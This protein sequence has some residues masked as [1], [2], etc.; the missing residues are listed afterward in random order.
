MFT[1]S[2]PKESKVDRDSLPMLA[3][4]QG[5]LRHSGLRL[6]FT[7][8][9]SFRL[10]T[11]TVAAVA[12][13]LCTLNVALII[14]AVGLAA[15]NHIDLMSLSYLV[16]VLACALVGG[17]VASA[18]PANAVGWLFTGSALS[19]A[20]M[21]CTGEY[22]IY[23]L[24]TQ[25][26]AL[27]AAHALAWPQTWLWEPGIMLIVVF[28]PLFFPDGRL[29]SPRWRPLVRLEALVAGTMGVVAAVV[30]R[31]AHEAGGDNGPALA[32]PLGIGGLQP[33]ARLIG[34]AMP[35]LLALMMV[36]SA[37]G[38]I[39]RFR[40][41]T[42]ATR[43]QMKWL[44]YAIVA[45]LAL[46]LL[47]KLYPPAVP[48]TVVE[49]A[50]IPVAV[51]IAVLHYRL[52]DIDHLINRTLVYAALTAIVAGIYVLLVGFVT[53]S[54]Q[55]R[56]SSLV[57]P[58]ATG[59]VAV[60]FQPLRERL[61]RTVNRLLYGQRDE[62]YAVLSRLGLRLEE[63]LAPEAVLSAIV[64]TVASALK[65][66]YVG[67]ALQDAE[68]LVLATAQGTAVPDPIR[69]PLVYQ[70]EAVGELLLAPRSGSDDFT[71][72][73]RRLLDDL[74]RQAGVAV[75]AV[76]LTAA[77]KRSRERLVSARD[78]ERRRLRRDL[79]DGLG[80]MLASLTLKLDAAR[81]LLT[82]DPAATDRLLV[83]LKGQAKSAVTDIR[84]LV[85][86][87]RPPALDDLGLRSALREQAM[88][89]DQEGLRVTVEVPE[90]LPP[91]PAAVEV[92][93]YR[94]AQEAI[95][96]VARHASARSCVVRLSLSQVVDALCLEIRDDGQG[97]SSDRRAGV[98]LTSMR[99]RAE[100]LGGSCDI[101][102]PS[103]GGTRVRAFLP[104]SVA[105]GEAPNR[106]DEAEEV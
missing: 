83:D 64:E 55:M 101:D 77:L 45:T 37:S 103:T 43:A 2:S 14:G 50:A 100:E 29:P 79:H 1:R 96:N 9:R 25:P 68:G 6:L 38:L 32:N 70:R 67:I 74:A 44:T 36:A 26:G 20:L 92:A 35:A 73:D 82:R 53:R 5:H 99:E 52:Y 17:L 24:Y 22:A 16:F 72:A 47:E 75:Q 78:E 51:G 69:L 42:G 85:Y 81:T 91:L 49:L 61:Q 18:R 90:H 10:S 57:A 31:V 66:P 102:A 13:S 86:A 65:L 40:R 4:S 62:P 94:I 87:L 21:E 63:T 3:P 104:C 39:L 54:F 89:Y 71:P 80:P 23:G 58:L 93:A 98:G 27:P 41:S 8:R 28:L 60:L 12:W 88:A 30:P 106:V 11:H 105:L 34:G 56:D 19:F 15:I 46:Y 97:I 95:T 7:A 84:R 76:Q 48:I 59:I 33:A